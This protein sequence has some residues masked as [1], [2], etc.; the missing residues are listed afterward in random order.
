MSGKEKTNGSLAM[1]PR[2]ITIPAA[3]QENTRKLRVAAYARVSSNSEDQKHSF[4]AQNAYFSKLITDNPDWELADIYADQGITGTSIDKRDDF[5]RMMEDCRKGRIDRI[6]VKSS[7]R[8]AR[9]TKESLEAVREL[10]A[11]GVSVYFEEQNID[12][13]QV[14]GEVLIAMFAALAQRESE[15]IS[16]RRRWSY[17]LQMSKGRF[18][19]YQAPLGFTRIDDELKIV[20]EEAAVIRRIFEEYLSGANSR[21]IAQRLN[22]GHVLDLDW[23]Y[24]LIDY[25][26]KNERYAG[27]ALLQKRYTTDAIPFKSKRNHGEKKQY[28]V[29]AI[30]DAI[31]SQETFDQAQKLRRERK[32]EQGSQHMYLIQNHHEAI[33]SREQFDAVQ[34]E[35]ARRRAQTG[36][37]KKSAPT[38]MSRYSGK[39]ALSG[40]LFCGECGTA[41][42]R[43]VWTQHGE[44][45]AVWR[46]SSRLDY[47]KKYCK[48][49]PTLDE[50]P[51]QQAVLA[52]INASMSGR[53]VLADQLVDAM[54]QEL[55]PVPGESM[56]LGDIDRAV[57]ELGKQFDMLLAEAANGDV[58]EYAERFRAI[59]TTMEELKRRKAAI[60]S[61]RQEQEQIGRRIH[62]AASAMTAVTMGITEWDDGVVYQM[63]EKVTVLADSRIKVTFRNGVE[64]EQTV[65]QPKRRKFA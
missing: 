12:T 56:S 54:E 28:F 1:A 29:E 23:K 41:Y 15:A 48:E 55:A 46:C 53:K 2:V 61:I 57:T 7:S 42:R 63:L 5:L 44:K 11:L 6:L 17:Q 30:N 24:K 64:I 37:T 43:V 4:A 8:F 51:L 22:D 52:A 58:D 20:P 59:S 19:T 27:N 35:L 60:L 32:A 50:A 38:G 62:A 34:M 31:I 40:L 47:G 16:N 9:N 3:S 13:A 18:N 45:R 25:I 65:D 49:S 39:Y 26:L 14:S 21:E 33:I 10:A 36:G